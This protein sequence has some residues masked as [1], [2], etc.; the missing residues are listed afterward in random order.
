M[1]ELN[2]GP[3]SYPVGVNTDFNLT[4]ICPAWQACVDFKMAI[5]SCSYCDLVW[6]KG[7]GCVTPE[8]VGNDGGFICAACLA[9]L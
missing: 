7:P 6:H 2:P 5:T 4:A 1:L 3:V 9:L 8:S